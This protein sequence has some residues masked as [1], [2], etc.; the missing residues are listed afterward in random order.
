[1]TRLQETLDKT[2]YDWEVIIVDDAS[3]DD[4]WETLKQLKPDY[5]KLKIARLSRNGGQHNAILCGLGMAS[6]DSV[7][8]MDD[9]LQNR[10]EDITLLVNKVAAGYDLAIAAF[11]EK[12][13]SGLRNMGGRLIDSIQRKIFGLPKNFQLTSFRA[14]RSS[15]VGHAVSMGGVFPYITA[16]LLSHTSN[17]TNVPVQHEPRPYGQSNYTMKRSFLL[18]FNL[19]LNY[20]PLPLYVVIALCGLALVFSVLLAVW[21]FWQT[22]AYGTGIQ[23]WASTMAGIAFFNSLTL[24]SLVVLGLYVSRISQQVTRSRVSFS[25]GEVIE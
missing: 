7:V 11:P 17:Y 24:L 18:A 25:L 1:M 19:L 6:G 16:M 20:S 9:D 5:S 12:Q 15:V 22:L 13:H 21:V 8:T 23:G 2:A 3:P 14:C 4:T 10:P